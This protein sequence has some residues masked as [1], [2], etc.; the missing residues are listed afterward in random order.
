MSGRAQEAIHGL[1]SML[2]HIQHLRTINVNTYHVRGNAASIL[3]SL[4]ELQELDEVEITCRTLSVAAERLTT[5]RPFPCLRELN[6]T[7]SSVSGAPPIFKMMASYS[8]LRALVIRNK[9]EPAEVDVGELLPSLRGHLSLCSVEVTALRYIGPLSYRFLESL[10]GIP[11]LIKLKLYTGGPLTTTDEELQSLASGLPLLQTLHLYSAST[12]Q[13]LRLT[14]NVLPSITTSCPFIEDIHITGIDASW[15]T[16]EI[17]FPASSSL[18]TL[19]IPNAP[20]RDAQAVASFLGRLSDRDTFIISSFSWGG[21]EEAG[22]M[23]R[24]WIE[25]EESVPA[26][27]RARLEDKAKLALTYK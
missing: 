20:I 17:T 1:A 26:I 19:S 13:S 18:N 9:N 24:L 15:P 27:R 12:D 5:E 8:R 4:A 6:L 2:L 7:S 16:T 22:R 10:C 3:I 23:R 21:T 14:I 25:V 11:A